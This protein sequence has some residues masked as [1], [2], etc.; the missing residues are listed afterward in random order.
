MHGLRAAAAPVR[1]WKPI[2]TGIEQDD[3]TEEVKRLGGCAEAEILRRGVRLPLPLSP[4]LSAHL[5]GASISVEDALAL[6][7]PDI[8]AGTWI[9]EGAGGVL[10]PIN[11]TELM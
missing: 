11:E 3:D 8:D 2:Q 10:V 1:Y 7:A 4:H 6:G 9:V 5:A